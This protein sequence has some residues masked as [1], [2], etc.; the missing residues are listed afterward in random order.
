MIRWTAAGAVAA[1]E[2]LQIRLA[3]RFD[4]RVSVGAPVPPRALS[5]EEVQANVRH[6]TEGHRGPRTRPVRQLVL[7]GL[8]DPGELDALA[9][10]VPGWRALGI[11]ELVLHVSA[12]AAAA[13]IG[14]AM[15]A[16]AD[17]V[18]VT[19][20]GIDDEVLA[21]LRGLP[22]GKLGVSVALTDRVLPRL[23]DLVRLLAEQPPA[24]LAWVW[25]FPAF[26]VA[27]PPM[28]AEVVQ[29][30]VVAGALALPGARVVHVPA[31]LD[32]TV[33]D[34][35]DLSARGRTRN[36]HYVDATHQLSE[37]LLFF[38]DLVQLAK[39]DRCRFCR[40]DLAC[41]G[42]AA[43]WLQQGRTGTLEPM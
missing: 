42:V 6:F 36:R 10:L 29:A 27:P 4:E 3:P 34:A 21:V 11:E 37:A 1:P 25:P 38:P 20:A 31:C 39:P 30:L 17:R 32:P 14:S 15:G 23:D 35:H 12:R 22:L 9:A 16:A 24:H 5:V 41:D 13:V 18:V 19:V 33:R 26:D 7:S 2:A 43:P 28:A 8:D 40:A